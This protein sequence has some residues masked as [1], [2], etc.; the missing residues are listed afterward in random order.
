MQILGVSTSGLTGPDSRLLSVVMALWLIS[1]VDSHAHEPTEQLEN[2]ADN[3]WILV[4]K[5]S[6]TSPL[7]IMAYSGGWYDPE[8]HQFCIF[9]GGHYNYSGNEVWCFDIESLSWNEMYPPDVLTRAPYDGGD[10]GAYNNYDNEKYPGALFK[11][12]GESIEAANP[13]ARHTY[14]QLEYVAGLGAVLWG[15]IAWGDHD[16]AW[17]VQCEDTWAFDYVR[18]RWRYLYDGSNPSPNVSPG[19]GA[20]AYASRD[21]RLYA[22]VLETTWLYDPEKNHWSEVRTRGTPPW[23][24]E[25]T[26]EYD[27]NHHTLYFFGGNYDRNLTLWRFN[28]EQR[29]W[30]ALRPDGLGP[31]GESSSGPGMAYDIHNDVLMI[32][33]GG[34]LWAYDP[35][36]NTWASFRPEVRPSDAGYVFGRFRYDPVNRGFWLH[37]EDDGEHATWFYRHRR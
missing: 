27:P 10:Q 16:M 28:I 15:G 11:P 3:T 4:D 36:A 35:D 33:F 37:V 34:T 21:H 24:I 19:V 8:N 18:A 30:K 29:H 14:D 17:C 20:S 1:A 13:A 22:K 2:V 12:A 9:G 31:T 23:T 25:G 32:Y 7:G 26:L 6:V 5:G